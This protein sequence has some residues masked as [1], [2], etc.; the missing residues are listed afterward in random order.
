MRHVSAEEFIAKSTRE[1]MTAEEHDAQVRQ[2]SIAARQA[3]G[4]ELN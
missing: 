4:P 2:E 1:P 3:R